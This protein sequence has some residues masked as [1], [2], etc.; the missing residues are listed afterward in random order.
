MRSKLLVSIPSQPPVACDRSDHAPIHPAR[1]RG[2]RMPDSV[3]KTPGR[4]R[5]RGTTTAASVDGSPLPNHPGAARLCFRSCRPSP[6][7]DGAN[8]AN[9]R[10]SPGEA[11]RAQHRGSHPAFTGITWRPSRSNTASSS[12]PGVARSARL[13]ERRRLSP[14]AGLGALF[15]ISRRTSDPPG[16]RRTRSG[17]PS[18]SNGPYRDRPSWGRSRAL[19]MGRYR[20]PPIGTLRAQAS[21]LSV[22]C[23]VLVE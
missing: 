10:R 19:G 14:N 16:N 3:Q 9:P 11:L 8:T 20:A 2:L 23:R 6:G 18:G 4:D 7:S 22:G 12:A 15:D 13:A 17:C 1:L 21:G 5:C